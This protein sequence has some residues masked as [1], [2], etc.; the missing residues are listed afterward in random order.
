MPAVSPKEEERVDVEEVG[1]LGL[2]VSR[3]EVGSVLPK[4]T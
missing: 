1:G 2:L 3:T 4:L